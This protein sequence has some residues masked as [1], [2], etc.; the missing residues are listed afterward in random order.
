[1]FCDK[2]NADGRAAKAGA[3]HRFTSKGEAC[4]GKFTLDAPRA[5]TRAEPK[6]QATPVTT[7][8]QPTFISGTRAAPQEV[9][10]R[11]LHSPRAGSGGSAKVPTDKGTTTGGSADESASVKPQATPKVETPSPQEQFDADLL[12][13]QQAKAAASLAGADTVL[14]GNLKR[15]E[16]AIPS[17]REGKDWVLA[18]KILVAANK[19]LG[20]AIA[21]SAEAAKKAEAA[22]TV[23]T[24]ETGKPDPDAARKA[25]EE[26]R[27]AAEE[28]MRKVEA[29]AKWPE[30]L[31]GKRDKLGQVREAYDAA[32][33]AND[34]V[35]ATRYAKAWQQHGTALLEEKRAA[36]EQNLREYNEALE[37]IGPSVREAVE[38]RNRSNCPADDA[39]TGRWDK[40]RAVLAKAK[41]DQRWEDT[42]RLI[43][44][45]GRVAEKLQQASREEA[46]FSAAQARYQEA[47][48]AA[49][50]Q[51]ASTAHVEK[52]AK[53]DGAIKVA[54]DAKDWTQASA[55]VDTA[56]TA[57]NEAIASAAAW[58]AYEDSRPATEEVMRKVD[59][60]ADW[61]AVLQPRLETLRQLRTTCKE[62]AEQ[63]DYAKAGGSAKLLRD[64]G[65]KLLDEKRLIDEQKRSYE[66]A[67]AGVQAAHQ[68]GAE[69]RAMTPCPADAPA[70][71]AWDRAIKTHDDAKA[72]QRWGPARDSIA[73]IESA[74]ATLNTARAAMDAFRRQEG[75]I[76]AIVEQAREF[77]AHPN[78]QGTAGTWRQARDKVKQLS[79]AKNWTLAADALPRLKSTSEELAKK[80]QALKAKDDVERAATVAPSFNAVRNL[81]I[82]IHGHDP[83]DFT[84]WTTE[85][86]AYASNYNAQRYVEAK[87]H[88]LNADQAARKLLDA[89]QAHDRYKLV[90]TASAERTTEDALAAAGKASAPTRNGFYAAHKPWVA[91]FNSNNWPEATNTFRELLKASNLLL[92]DVA[93]LAAYDKPTKD[94]IAAAEKESIYPPMAGTTAAA[95][96]ATFG[97][98][99]ETVNAAVQAQN[100]KEAKRCVPTLKSAADGLLTALTAASPRDAQEFDKEWNVTEK[101]V[102]A[103]KEAKALAGSSIP[104]LELTWRA[105]L[106]AEAAM[107]KAKDATQWVK[108]RAA[109]AALDQAAVRFDAQYKEGVAFEQAYTA[110]RKKSVADAQAIASEALPHLAAD[111]KAFADV[112]RATMSL[113]AAGNYAQAR[114]QLVELERLAKAL[115]DKDA[116]LGA[117]DSPDG[118]RIRKLLADAKALKDR[119]AEPARDIDTSDI[120]LVTGPADACIEHLAAASPNVEKAVEELQ[121]AQTQFTAAER[122]RESA[123]TAYFKDASKKIEEAK[124]AGESLDEG[125]Q[126]L[127]DKALDSGTAAIAK[128]ADSKHFGSATAK[129]RRLLEEAEAWMQAKEAFDALAPTAQFIPNVAKLKKLVDRAGGGKVLDA[130][131]QARMQDTGGI[132]SQLVN[133]AMEARFGF[134]AQRYDKRQVEGSADTEEGNVAQLAGAYTDKSI[135]QTYQVMAKVPQQ[136]WTA[137][138]DAMIVYDKNEDEKMLGGHFSSDGTERKVYMYC[139]RP[140]EHDQKFGT[141]QKILPEGEQV[142]ENCRP[143]DEDPSPLFDF[144]LLHEAAHAE[145]DAR[146]YMAANGGQADHGGWKVHKGPD[147]FAGEVAKHFGY[148]EAYIL[149]TLRSPGSSPPRLPASLPRNGDQAQWDKARQDAVSWCRSVRE[150]AQPWEDPGLSRAVAIQGR[151][152]QESSAG[153]WVSYDLAARARGISSYQFRSPAEWFAELYAAYFS[154]KL[155]DGHPSAKW[156]KTFKSSAA[157]RA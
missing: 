44:E 85:Q 135:A 142:E 119:V 40:V 89:M 116:T 60:V 86:A 32:V 118:Q 46:Q 109:L 95:R 6:P 18:N 78:L 31:Q 54:G 145:D 154:K 113:I 8:G 133:V 39:T 51:G 128:A 26:V 35:S 12:K 147:E 88:L 84:R 25:F 94:A 120:A 114:P 27:A 38:I 48:S 53:A 126:A 28:V 151:V 19:F 9:M 143:A 21:S 30:A 74:A 20:E 55:Q 43:P 123:W 125:L 70:M 156:L 105:L 14:L 77:D 75:E 7:R 91:A 80:G 72:G 49:V 129:T 144:T 101:K 140:G 127:R 66:Q 97:Q 50:L 99:R 87:E 79:D 63:G 23:A 149:A 59:E 103:A 83:A 61:P 76:A 71:Q 24:E 52:L 62:A 121:K 137:K 2:C 102:K 65:T 68:Q 96:F 155:K 152:Y 37:A 34:H 117:K 3:V 134:K 124:A 104:A 47:K 115:I 100:F 112:H 67:Y 132:S 110:A 58:K 1:M 29:V 153:K 148:D 157:A 122:K 150:S 141:D 11:A 5:E 130:I 138:V 15:L 98:A 69:V 107:E 42:R 131:V 73:G 36:E 81:T 57:L 33:K 90:G 64:D 17:A 82:P 93:Y 22:K 111:I 92:D 4:G 108:A 13:Y 146:G 10:T 45:L 106:A 16:D 139:G 56:N 136:H 41:E